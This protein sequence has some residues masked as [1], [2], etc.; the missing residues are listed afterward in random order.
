MSRTGRAPTTTDWT[1]EARRIAR[2]RRAGEVG[3]APSR[4]GAGAA[5]PLSESEI[6]EAEAELG[7][8]FPDEYRGYLRR[9]EV[10]G[11]VNRLCRSTEGWG[12]HGDPDTNYD[13]LTTAF[14][15]PDSYRAHEDE[16]IGREPLTQDFPE[17]DAYQAA[18]EQW[19][20]EYE[21]FQERRT[22]GAVFI[23]DNGCG[24]STLLVVTGP[25]RGSPW[26]DGRATCDQILPLDLGGQPVSF[27]DWLARRSMDL[28]GW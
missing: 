18:F 21:V 25:H 26:F 13:L 24:F 23:Q 10:G 20:A 22:A 9:Q 12:W 27:T 1:A 6:R 28:L 4:Q 16:L 5:A 7:I 19:D 3:S 11:A 15:H 8:A 2:G 17:H 14:P